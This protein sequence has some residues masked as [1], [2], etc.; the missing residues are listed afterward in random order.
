M[1]SRKVLRTLP[2]KV[3]QTQVC[4]LGYGV[5]LPI[6]VY[7]KIKSHV[8]NVKLS[9]VDLTKRVRYAY[10]ETVFGGE[11]IVDGFV[12]FTPLIT[13]QE[14]NF[15]FNNEFVG[16]LQDE[17]N[18]YYLDHVSFHETNIIRKYNLSYLLRQVNINPN[19]LIRKSKNV[20]GPYGR[21]SENVKP[22]TTIEDTYGCYIVELNQVNK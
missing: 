19:Q 5:P 14:T 18:P 10:P 13:L 9:E 16:P 12:L 1:L 8:N 3:G 11:T 7:D 22:D 17:K 6:S 15:N 4:A 20:I 2:L 21:W